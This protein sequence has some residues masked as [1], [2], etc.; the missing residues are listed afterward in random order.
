MKNRQT[1][2]ILKHYVR[3]LRRELAVLMEQHPELAGDL[4][5]NIFGHEYHTW[6]DLRGLVNVADE[7]DDDIETLTPTPQ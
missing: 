2:V 7:L 6:P 1:V 4:K 3:S 5:T